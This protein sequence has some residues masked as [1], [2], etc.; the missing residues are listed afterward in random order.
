VFNGHLT[1]SFFREMVICAKAFFDKNGHLSESLFDRKAF[2][3][4][5]KKV[6]YPEFHYTQ[7]PFDRKLQ[8]KFYFG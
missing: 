8:F 7:G 2:D 1:E 4:N 6:I 5:Q 3:R